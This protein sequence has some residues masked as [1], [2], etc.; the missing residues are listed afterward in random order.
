MKLSSRHF[1]E[2]LLRFLEFKGIDISLQL[3]D[4][5][6]VYLNKN[7]KFEN[8]FIIHLTRNG[9]EKIPLSSVKKAE[10]YII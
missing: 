6:R 10:F 5:T 8:G 4:G 3:Q 9:E 7:R 1:E 2:K